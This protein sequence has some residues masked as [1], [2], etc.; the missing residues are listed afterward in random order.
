M[1][2]H[3]E[4]AGQ[5]DAG[6]GLGKRTPRGRDVGRVRLLLRF[7]LCLLATGWHHR[8]QKSR[9]RRDEG[10]GDCSLSQGSTLA[11]VSHSEI[12]ARHR[13]RH[14][15]RKLVTRRLVIAGGF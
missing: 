13:G 11:R 12:V 3:D 14:M 15:P 1:I 5:L 2:D 10:G 6:A 7:L 9:Q 4:F 8:N